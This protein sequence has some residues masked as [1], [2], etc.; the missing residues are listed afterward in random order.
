MIKINRT[1]LA[2]KIILAI[3]VFSI[4]IGFAC[5]FATA[6]EDKKTTKLDFEA[7]EYLTAWAPEIIRERDNMLIL[8]AYKK[9]NLVGTIDGL[10]FT[11][12]DEL[13]LYVIM[14]TTT[15]EYLSFG[16]VTMYIEWEGLTGSFSGFVIATGS[17]A[18]GDGRF[19]LRGDG[20]FEGM[21]LF[22]IVWVIDPYYGVNGLSGTIK[23]P[24]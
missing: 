10:A 14:D 2:P 19:S 18:G 20:D 24:N 16:T 11:G 4:F 6:K 8:R 22:G 9:A 21:K 3:L 7:T 12:Y 17:M 1:K 15:G 23:I 5:T 13:N